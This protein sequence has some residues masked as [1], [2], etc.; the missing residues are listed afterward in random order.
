[1]P[2]SDGGEPTEHAPAVRLTGIT[3]RYGALVANEAITLDVLA[4]QVLGLLGENGAGKSTLMKV[5]FG[6]TS[7]DEGTIEVN[8]K[9]AT[10]T[11][12]AQAMRHGIGMVTQHF[13]LVLPMSVAENVALG[14]HRG[15]I[16]PAEQAA[17]VAAAG[18]RFG[19]AVEPARRVESL[20]VG[21]RQRVE[22]L[23]A[24]YRDCRVLI[25]DEPTA[26]LT[27]QEVTRLFTT[28]RGLTA[29]G[30]AVVMI[31]HKLHEIREIC[32][33]VVVLHRGRVAGEAKTALVSDQQLVEMMIGG[34]PRETSAATG[35]LDAETAQAA[36]AIVHLQRGPRPRATTSTV[37]ER[38]AERERALSI[39]ALVVAGGMRTGI[40]GARR[41]DD[42]ERPALD[43][44]SIGVHRGEIVGV[45]GV[46]GNGQAELVE[47]LC[48]MRPSTSGSI[49]VGG[50]NVTNANPTAM[51]RAGLGRLAED[52]HQVIVAE[53]SVAY[54]LVLERL[55]EFRTWRGLDEAAIER[56]AAALIE[57]FSIRATPS[58]T[59]GT[60][61][62]GNIQKTLLA[63]VLSAS[64][65][66]IVV[67]QPTRGL[68]IGATAYV[69]EQLLAAR[70]RGAGVLMI[71][72]DIDELLAVADR[73]VVLSGGR[74][75]GEHTALNA[76]AE[77][78]G[79]MMLAH[80]GDGLDVT[81]GAQVLA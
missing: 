55:D 73:I 36:G 28:I 79:A 8:G 43:R 77:Q 80:A 33:R 45:A 62:G 29:A 39:A 46:S 18:E 57:Q 12:P 64:P 47:A 81:P 31:S 5:L 52:R 48:G 51:V 60:L 22:I 41:A 24:L 16:R 21:E 53:M 32:E 2:P 66:A 30:I 58:T 69:H 27:P 38:S 14:T 76:T 7:P 10:M 49:T 74:I 9:P 25:L 44:V 19:I 37:A 34:A 68:D 42:G 65:T 50:R 1:M 72:E 6:L 61:S 70:E 13:S 71:S 20:S 15:W 17:S 11:S 63:R 3:K 40:R 26:V 75:V 35:D 4:G 59:M 78:I 67:A 54:N 56:H 23:K